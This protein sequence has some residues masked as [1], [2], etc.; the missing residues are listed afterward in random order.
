MSSEQPA[1]AEQN[2]RSPRQ[3][4]EPSDQAPI[5]RRRGPRKDGNTKASEEDVTVRRTRKP[6]PENIPVS[7]EMVG[8]TLTGIVLSVIRKGKMRFGFIGIG[9]D[10][11]NEQEM[12]RIY[13]NIMELSDRSVFLRRGYEVQFEVKKDSQDRPFASGIILTEDGKKVAAEREEYIAKRRAENPEEQGK[14]STRDRRTPG[15]DKV[16]S[17]RISCEGKTDIR[18]MEFNLRDSMG[19]LK[20]AVSKEFDVETPMNLYLVTKDNPTGLF[21]TKQLL[22]SMDPSDIVNL[23]EKKESVEK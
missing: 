18:T 3:R 5:R 16:V 1:S 19:R 11:T 8:E 4:R 2:R 22:A 20:A 23:S 21:L 6:R 7:N 14:R 12:P 17:I 10:I 13:F 15:E 9:K